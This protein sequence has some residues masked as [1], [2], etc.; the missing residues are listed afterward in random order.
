MDEFVKTVFTAP[1]A[2]LFIVAGI[3]FLLIAVVGNISGKIEPGVKGRITSGV[4]GLTFVLIGLAMHLTQKEQIKH[5]QL[6]E[7]PRAPTARETELPSRAEYSRQGKLG[8]EVATAQWIFQVRNITQTDEYA[9]RYY[10]EGRVIRP[11]GKNDTLIV[12][13]ARLK[14]RLDKTR[15]PVLTERNPGNTG[16]FDE[17]GRSYQP[18]DFDARQLSDKIMSYEAAP[19]LPGAVAD[20]ALVFSIP[21]GAKPKTL[22]FTCSTYLMDKGT[23]VQVGLPVVLEQKATNLSN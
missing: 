1:V 9:E 23:D 14:N 18:V 2:T 3:L 21:K 13:E 4:L 12:I 7:A 15:S 19:V 22:N 20:F 6:A 11:K 5:D 16:L 17:E 8:D 10:Q